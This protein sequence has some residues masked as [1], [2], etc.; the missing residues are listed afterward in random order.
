VYGQKFEGGQF[1]LGPVDWAETQWHNACAPGTKY[2]PAVQQAEGTLLAG[3]WSGIPDVAAYC[4]A[5]ISVVTAKSRSA[6]RPGARRA[7]APAEQ[8][9]AAGRRQGTS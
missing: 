4:D 3:L 6:S 1:H 2:A 7:R 8:R 5:C 9:A